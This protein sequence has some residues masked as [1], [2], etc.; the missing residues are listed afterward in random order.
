MQ[1]GTKVQGNC[2]LL[3]CSPLN[4]IREKGEYPWLCTDWGASLTEHG[5]VNESSSADQR[6]LSVPARILRSCIRVVF[7]ETSTRR[8]SDRL[9]IS[10]IISSDY[11]KQGIQIG[12]RESAE[13]IKE[14]ET[15]IKE[16]NSQVKRLTAELALE[17]ARLLLAARVAGQHSDL[18]ASFISALNL[19]NNR[20]RKENAQLE[21][22]VLCWLLM[23]RA[24]WLS[25]Q[26]ILVASRAAPIE[27]W[28][29]PYRIWVV[30]CKIR[31][32][33]K[34]EKWKIIRTMS[35]CAI[36]GKQPALD[37][38]HNL[39]IAAHTISKRW[40]MKVKSNLVNIYSQKIF[41]MFRRHF[42]L[43]LIRWTSQMSSEKR[44]LPNLNASQ[45]NPNS[46]LQICSLM[47]ARYW[48]HYW[49]YIT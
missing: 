19:D 17:A 12:K 18:S 36:I 47:S 15:L 33:G 30:T 3:F 41:E 14:Q 2:C 49:S 45:H 21:Q 24:M 16:R 9:G 39:C 8:A 44:Y 28:S 29:D 6:V 22:W 10:T 46:T 38:R 43:I 31:S 35:T 11:S 40:I 4:K 37:F 20:Q 34:K 42:S 1:Q 5:L 27:M 26:G 32:Q 25:V 13:K 23:S 48:I 7:G